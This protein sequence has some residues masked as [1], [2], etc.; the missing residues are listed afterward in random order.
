MQGVM[1]VGIRS[2]RVKGLMMAWMG[3]VRQNGGDSYLV[4]EEL[5]E[6]FWDGGK[7]ACR[8]GNYEAHGGR[9]EHVF[10]VLYHIANTCF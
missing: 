6:V 10:A 3:L 9:C 7:W 5:Y 8:C 2:L 4:G 1:C